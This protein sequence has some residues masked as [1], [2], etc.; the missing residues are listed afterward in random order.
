MYKLVLI[1]RNIVLQP[2]VA[3][4]LTANYHHAFDKLDVVHNHFPIIYKLDVI[5]NKLV[6]TRT[7]G[8][9]EPIELQGCVGINP[10]F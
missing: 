1:D 7:P 4:K 9:L 2:Y 3:F 10:G 5:H 8:S 6:I